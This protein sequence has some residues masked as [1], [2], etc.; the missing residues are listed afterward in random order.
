MRPPAACLLPSRPCNLPGELR[1]MVWEPGPSG[2]ERYGPGHP[3]C[4][5]SSSYTE[6][7]HHGPVAVRAIRSAAQLIGTDLTLTAVLCEIVANT[8][9]AQDTMRS[10]SGNRAVLHQLSLASKP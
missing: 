7:S 6:R 2:R 9:V 1:L 10:V 5:S 3:P 4:E 8:D